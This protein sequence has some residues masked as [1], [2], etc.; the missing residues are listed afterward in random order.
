MKMQKQDIDERVGINRKFLLLPPKNPV[1][2]KCFLQITIFCKP[3][4]F[5]ESSYEEKRREN[6]ILQCKHC[7][8]AAKPI[9]V[10]Q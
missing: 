9:N 2:Y 6:G 10:Y 7:A 5:A 4:R 8:M 1:H 3:F